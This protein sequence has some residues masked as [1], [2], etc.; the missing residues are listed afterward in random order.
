MLLKLKSKLQNFKLQEYS[1][2]APS[3]QPNLAYLESNKN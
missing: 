2:T 3:T 1:S